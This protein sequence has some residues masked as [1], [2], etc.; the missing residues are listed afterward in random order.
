MLQIHYTIIDN[1][2]A[3]SHHHSEYNY[4]DMIVNYCYEEVNKFI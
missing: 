2:R 4:A 1:S 3:K